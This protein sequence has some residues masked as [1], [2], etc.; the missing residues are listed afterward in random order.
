[1]VKSIKKS[2]NHHHAIQL[3]LYFITNENPLLQKYLKAQRNE[4]IQ[5]RKLQKEIQNNTEKSINSKKQSLQNHVNSQIQLIKQEIK[6]LENQERLMKNEK[7]KQKRE[8]LLECKNEQKKQLG[9]ISDKLN[10]D[11]DDFY[12]KD[13]VKKMDFVFESRK[14]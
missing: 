5:S 11:W 4:I 12:R 3:I 7:E 9:L 8:L 2:V 1:L 14:K 10:V 6:Q 13:K